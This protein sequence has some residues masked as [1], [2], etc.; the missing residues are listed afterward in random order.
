MAAMH[1]ELVFEP[2]LS[3][4]QAQNSGGKSQT[5][6]WDSVHVK[7]VALGEDAAI[8]RQSLKR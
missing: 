5:I 3:A 7:P 8:F 1:D 6:V 4:I 2:Q